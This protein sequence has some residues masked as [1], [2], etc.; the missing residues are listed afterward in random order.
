LSVLQ[1]E[2]TW[3]A[4]YGAFVNVVQ[5][6]GKKF[7]G[8]IHKSELSWG[9]V[10]TPVAIVQRGMSLLHQCWLAS[11]HSLA[12]Q[13]VAWFRNLWQKYKEIEERSLVFPP[14]MIDQSGSIFSKA[15][16]V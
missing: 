4:S 9:A 16:V 6:D 15:T 10:I 5:T 2:V 12:Q 14:Q 8:L 1:G 7:E 3:V 11:Y 13:S